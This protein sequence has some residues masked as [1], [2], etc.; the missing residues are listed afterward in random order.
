MVDSEQENEIV[1]ATDHLDLVVAEL[2][3]PAVAGVVGNRRL[4][5]SL[6]NLREVTTLGETLTRRNAEQIGER[7][8]SKPEP[9]VQ[10]V[11]AELRR[12]FERRFDGW[13]PTMG[14]NRTLTGVQF[15]PVSNGGG[16]DR[17]VAVEVADGA[18]RA[19]VPQ[20]R[21]VAVGLFDTRLAAHSRLSGRYLADPD[22]LAA[23]YEPDR[24]RLWWEGHATFIAGVIRQHAP[25]AVLDVRTALRP[26]PVQEGAPRGEEWTMP[27]W[28]FAARLA[29]YQDAGVSVINLSVGVA[30]HDGKPPLV[31]E[32]AIAQ[33]TPSIVVVAAA[34]NH[35]ADKL[36]PEKRAAAGLPERGAPMFPAALDNV[37]AVGALATDGTAAD[38]NPR[39]A[40]GPET[41]PWIDTFAPGV[42][43]VSTYL[44]DGRREQVLVP[45]ADGQLDARGFTG[46]AKWS[47]T[48]F[49]AGV[50]TAAAADLAAQNLAAP[51][52]VVRLRADHPRPTASVTG[53]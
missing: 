5:L 24:P 49:A 19:D 33:L 25:S 2:G 43:L 1:V 51:E 8:D 53:A 11:L 7:L 34:G 50:I 15:K 45:G 42:D 22:A 6:V 38:F 23:A 37:V 27:L 4:G 41:A 20:L 35:G 13:I 3:E 14:R 26:G 52:I 39:G 31:L 44:G 9:G 10:E 16:V 47:G 48:S 28:D 40:H 36:S 30:T 17:P 46:W 21:R 32:R 12:T 29:D 18:S